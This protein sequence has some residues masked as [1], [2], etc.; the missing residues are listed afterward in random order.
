MTQEFLFRRIAV[1]GI[2]LIGS[3]FA[4][5][6]REAGL[7]ETVVAGDASAKHCGMALELEIADVATPGLREAVRDADLVVLATPVGA[8]G[9]VM[10]QIA[11][12]LKPGCIVMDVGSVKEAVVEAVSPLVPEGVFYIPAHP[13]AGTENSGPEAGFA[14]L[15]RGRWIILTPPAPGLPGQAEALTKVRAAWEKG[16]GARVALMTPAQHDLILATTSHVPH[17]LAF[18]LMGTAD[19]LATALDAEVISYSAGTFRDMTRVA[20]SDPTMWRDIFLNNKTAVLDILGRLKTQMTTLEK[21][22][23]SDDGAALMDYIGHVRG[24]RRTLASPKIE[25]LPLIEATEAAEG[26]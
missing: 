5:A 26:K 7:V 21:A 17:I 10:G 24:L 19:A 12:A 25:P 8:F 1:I 2:G 15:F 14:E 13:I 3:S 6:L 23:E 20:A 18:S 16:C 11:A 22:I 4:L 9:A